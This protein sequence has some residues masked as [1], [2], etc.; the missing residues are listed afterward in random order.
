MMPLAPSE[1]S[2]VPSRPCPAEGMKIPEHLPSACSTSG[3]RTTWAKCGEPISSSPSATSTRF[4]GSLRPAPWMACSAARNAPS[5][6]FW[7]TAPRPTMH[8]PKPGLSTRRA[9]KGGE[10]HSRGSTCLTSYMK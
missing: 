5:G 8:L 6:P 4:T 2:S 9:S 7:F 10:L 3:E 1:I